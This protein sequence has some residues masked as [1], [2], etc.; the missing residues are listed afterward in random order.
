[1]KL[2]HRTGPGS[3]GLNLREL[4]VKQAIA[5]VDARI[6]A[7]WQQVNK[8]GPVVS[9]AKRLRA[10][11]KLSYAKIAERLGTGKTTAFYMVSGAQ[12][13]DAS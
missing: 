13:K 7:F 8:D 2:L 10:E 4:L 11:E 12:W 3:V 1:M 9:E 5:A 6:E